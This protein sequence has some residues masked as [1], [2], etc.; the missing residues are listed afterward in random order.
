MGIVLGLSILGSLLLKSPKRK[1]SA[2]EPHCSPLFRII[3]C[4]ARL[5][6]Y[7]HRFRRADGR[8]TNSCIHVSTGHRSRIRLEYTIRQRSVVLLRNTFPDRFEIWQQLFL[9]RILSCP[10]CLLFSTTSANC[11][12]GRADT[13]SISSALQLPC[14]NYWI[15]VTAKCE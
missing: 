1:V 12:E 11:R 5:R 9:N 3:R 14:W 13:V 2:W 4:K 10:L 7:I 6:S 8:L 15:M